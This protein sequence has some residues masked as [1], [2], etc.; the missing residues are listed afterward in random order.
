LPLDR[1]FRT[2]HHDTEGNAAMVTSNLPAIATPLD[3][4]TLSK[5]N[6]ATEDVKLKLGSNIDPYECAANSRIC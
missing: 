3:A 1:K 6:A 5:L 4:G 2:F